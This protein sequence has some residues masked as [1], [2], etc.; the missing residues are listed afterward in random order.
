MKF[1]FSDRFKKDYKNLPKPIQGAI[2][3][4]LFLLKENPHHPSLDIKKN[5]RPKKSLAVQGNKRL[6]I[7]ISNRRKCL[8]FSSWEHMIF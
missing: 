4:Q 6:S 5:E 7:H 3:K 8:Y 2:D 1:S